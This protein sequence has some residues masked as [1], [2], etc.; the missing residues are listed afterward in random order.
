MSL[1][2][3]Y[4]IV[5]IRP[6]HYD[7]LIRLYRRCFGLRVDRAALQAKYD[8]SIF[9]ASHIGHLALDAE[10]SPA[11]Y[12]GVFPIRA[13]V[14]G[15]Q[16]LAA[17][18]G[19][20]MTDPDHQRRGLFVTLARKTYELA[21]EEG[22]Q[23][24][25][26]FPNESS[27]PGFRD[28]LDWVFHGHMVDLKLTSGAI[29]LAEAA[30]RVGVLRGI[31]TLWVRMLRGPRLPGPFLEP[32][33]AEW[34]GVLHDRD[35]YSYKQAN[36]G[37]WVSSGVVHLYVK[38]AV[39][40]YVGEIVAPAECGVEDIL[41][42]IRRTA[43]R[44][45]CGKAVYSCSTNHPL[46]RSIGQQLTPKRSLPIGYC[47]LHPLSELEGMVFSRVDYDTF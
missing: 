44:F 8:T 4:R 26:G 25:F 43:V 40:L 15:R 17:Q 32:Q 47:V 41:H 42:A 19:D 27:L 28:K 30:S 24:V 18:S 9:G 13:A 31:H 2:T 34:S 10:G 45:A 21:R 16:L 22:I 23:F 20:T 6:E 14:N 5:R 12:Y 7:H 1:P 33:G 36:G 38:P 46:Y 29:P 37:F 35:F 3:D 39:H 11:A